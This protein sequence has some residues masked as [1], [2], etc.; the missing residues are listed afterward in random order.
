MVLFV[1]FVVYAP[2]YKRKR[3]FCYRVIT[4]IPFRFTL[5][6]ALLALASA[7]GGKFLQ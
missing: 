4:M 7:Y 5:I 1:L 2:V 6:S 3:C